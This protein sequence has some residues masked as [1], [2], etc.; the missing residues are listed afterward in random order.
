MKFE[1]DSVDIKYGGN[2]VLEE[3]IYGVKFF[4]NDFIF[5]FKK[6]EL[7]ES[8]IIN[9]FNRFYK[10]SVEFFVDSEEMKIIFV[11]VGFN[12]VVKFLFESKLIFG[13]EDVL[14]SFKIVC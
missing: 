1:V 11:D 8:S 7:F 12:L 4:E 3:R 2:I 14:V 6:E 9:N 10:K 13:N 5:I